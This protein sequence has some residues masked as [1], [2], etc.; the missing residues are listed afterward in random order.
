MHPETNQDTLRKKLLDYQNN[1]CRASA[2][3][4]MLQAILIS[5]PNS[6]NKNQSIYR[7]G[8]CNSSER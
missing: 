4:L 2:L 5:Q 7:A 6:T 3:S 1:S 8:I